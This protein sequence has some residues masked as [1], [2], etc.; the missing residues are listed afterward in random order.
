MTETPVKKRPQ[1]RK[2]K[3]VTVGFYPEDEN[4]VT[5]IRDVRRLDSDS[6]A[7]RWAL[8]YADALLIKQEGIAA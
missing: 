2:V 5:R 8:R 6:A 1:K 3:I 7:I 4:A